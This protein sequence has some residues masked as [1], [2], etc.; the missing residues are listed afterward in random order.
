MIQPRREPKHTQN[1]TQPIAHISDSG[2]GFAL[3]SN[4]SGPTQRNGR[5]GP[6]EAIILALAESFKTIL[7]KLTRFILAVPAAVTRIFS[8]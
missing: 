2:A 3:V 7:P 4:S 5:N 1:D 6:L 8:Y